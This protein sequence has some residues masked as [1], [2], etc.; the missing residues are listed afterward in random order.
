MA[1][2][3]ECRDVRT[4]DEQNIVKKKN[5]PS[6][7]HSLHLSFINVDESDYR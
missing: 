1:N 3:M 2:E 5:K 4:E 6:S 7:A